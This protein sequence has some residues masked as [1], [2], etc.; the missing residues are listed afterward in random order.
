VGLCTK[1]MIKR[2]EAFWFPGLSFPNKNLNKCNEYSDV[3]E[4]TAIENMSLFCILMPLMFG[5]GVF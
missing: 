2:P 5:Y 3:H 4:N 1:L